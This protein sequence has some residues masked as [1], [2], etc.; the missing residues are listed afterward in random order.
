M[1]EWLVRKES[2]IWELYIQDL[3]C[4]NSLMALMIPPFLGNRSHMEV[5]IMAL[6][7]GCK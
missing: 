4:Q 2:L 7:S 5:L 6:D 1:N 3:M